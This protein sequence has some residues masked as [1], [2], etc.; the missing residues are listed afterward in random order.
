VVD[1]PST[2]ELEAAHCWE[3]GDRVPGRPA[4]TAFR[5]RVRYHQSCWREEHGHPSGSQPMV[6]RPGGRGPRLVGSRLPLEYARSTGANFAVSAGASSAARAR[7]STKEPHQ[8]LNAQRMWADLLSPEAFACNL[9]GSLAA[10]PE[11]AGRALARL[12]PDVPGDVSDVRFEHSPGWLDPSFL[13]NLMSFSAAVELELQDGSS[14]VVAFVT[15]YYD[16]I[17]R[18]V[19][20]PT[21]LGRYVAVHHASGGFRAGALDAVNGTD[22]LVL[23]LRHLLLLSMLQH[24]SGRWTWGRFVVVHPE[25]NTDF[26]EACDRYR[27]LLTDRDDPTFSSL[28]MEAL[29]AS[30]ALPPDD[31]AALRERYVA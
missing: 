21:R 20:K 4:M 25:G 24:P 19:P 22:L 3:P 11:P 12:F 30:G 15:P 2:L 27:A 1:E 29:L 6:A 9:F 7:L 28:T 10:D 26:V 16:R 31:V 18:E 23:W 14:G 8:S 17:K 13:G 5:R